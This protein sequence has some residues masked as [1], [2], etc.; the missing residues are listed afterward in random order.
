LSEQ[1]VGCFQE[2][3]GEK[4]KKGLC[5]RGYKKECLSIYYG[6]GWAGENFNKRNRKKK[7][8]KRA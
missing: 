5:S 4:G 7:R 2:G 1:R 6:T 3:E 8:G